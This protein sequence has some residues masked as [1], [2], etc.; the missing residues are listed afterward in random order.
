MIDLKLEEYSNTERY[1]DIRAVFT[2]FPKPKR[3]AESID[4][5]TFHLVFETEKQF[6]LYLSRSDIGSVFDPA[7]ILLASGRLHSTDYDDFWMVPTGKYHSLTL[8]MDAISSIKQRT[9][10]N[11]LFES[12]TEDELK[13]IEYEDGLIEYG[14]SMTSSMTEL[15]IITIDWASLALK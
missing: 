14:F 12:N 7:D 4:K 1:G 8:Q 10:I 15:T 3:G 13:K 11:E 6:S 5:T 2:G 9:W